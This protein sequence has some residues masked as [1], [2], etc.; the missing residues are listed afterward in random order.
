MAIYSW[1]THFI[2]ETLMWSPMSSLML[3]TQEEVHPLSGGQVPGTVDRCCT[4]VKH[5]EK[6]KSAAKMVELVS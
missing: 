1:V 6:G 4:V 5:N 2:V 3:I